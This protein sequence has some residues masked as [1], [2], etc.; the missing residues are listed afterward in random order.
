MA[1]G[2]PANKHFK[3][4]LVRGSI[5]IPGLFSKKFN[6]GLIVEIVEPGTG[7][8]I[9]LHF[10]STGIS[11]YYEDGFKS[12]FV[13]TDSFV[14]QTTSLQYLD[15]WKHCVLTLGADNTIA[16]ST[17]TG[18]KNLF[19]NTTSKQKSFSFIAALVCKNSGIKCPENLN[20][21]SFR[22]FRELLGTCANSATV[23]RISHV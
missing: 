1:R 2:L 7:L 4:H 6:R 10:K 18:V 15:V 17:I 23:M 11:F 21:Y 9:F 16:Q 8:S 5:S 14:V 20:Q 22:K 13:I 12:H 19:Q 3:I